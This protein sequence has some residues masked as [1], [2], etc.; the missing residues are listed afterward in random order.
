MRRDM[1]C[2]YAIDRARSQ[3]VSRE[4]SYVGLW[5]QPING[6][7]DD[8]GLCTTPLECPGL[9]TPHPIYRIENRIVHNVRRESSDDFASERNMEK[10]RKR[11]KKKVRDSR[12]S[13]GKRWKIDHRKHSPPLSH[14]HA[15]IELQSARRFTVRGEVFKGRK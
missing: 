12:R 4:T 3:S 14:L 8:R 6:S 9:D 1:R 11:E 13:T 15:S 10:K 5:A 7:G 2:P